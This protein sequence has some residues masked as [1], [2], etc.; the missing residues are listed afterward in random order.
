ML[1]VFLHGDVLWLPVV[2][3]HGF[4]E[5]IRPLVFEREDVEEHGF[6]AV[7]DFFGVEGEFGLGLIE[8]EGAA[9]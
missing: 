3:L 6:L 9:S 1:D 5:V 4:V 7:D 2:V 8:D